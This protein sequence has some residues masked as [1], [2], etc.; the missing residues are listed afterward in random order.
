MSSSNFSDASQKPSWLTADPALY[1]EFEGIINSVHGLPWGGRFGVTAIDLRRYLEHADSGGGRTELRV[2]AAVL[3]RY[4]RPLLAIS[5]GAYAFEGARFWRR[6]L[7]IAN[8]DIRRAVSATAKIELSGAPGAGF[9]GT[10]FLIADRVLLTSRAAA[11]EVRHKHDTLTAAVRFEGGF[12]A[13]IAEVLFASADF[14]D[15]FAFLVVEGDAPFPQPVA[16]ARDAANTPYVAAVAYPVRDSRTGT[17]LLDLVYGDNFDRLCIAPGRA[18]SGDSERSLTH[19]CATL[20]DCAGAIL[21]NLADGSVAGMHVAGFLDRAGVAVGSATILKAMETLKLSPALPADAEDED[22]GFEARRRGPEDYAN[23]QALSYREDFL[24]VTVLMPSPTEAIKDDVVS[25]DGPDGKTHVLTYTHFAVVMSRS[26]KMC[27]YTACNLNG[28][29]LVP[30]VRGGD[31]W[32]I[33]PR[34]ERSLQAGHELYSG[35][36]LNRGHMV[37]RLDPVWGAEAELADEDTFHFTNA[38]PQ[39]KELNQKTWSDLE[40]YVL[41]NAGSHNLKV[42]V[43]TGPVFSD[44][45]P[46]YRGFRLPLQFWKV[47]VMVKDDGELLATAYILSQADLL[48]GL[49]FVFGEF[50]TYQLPLVELE[51]MTNLDFG[52]LRNY[53]PKSQDRDGFESVRE[54]YTV[55]RGPEDLVMG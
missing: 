24:G 4:A 30:L 54:Q 20:G 2:E 17:A 38:C 22:D 26:R 43:F 25:Y 41:D 11:L 28:G 46:D 19:D 50:R 3:A 6:R 31:S 42:T 53:D 39:H 51:E 9:V 33:D 27:L 1:K 37:R 13:R 49:E 21:L 35:S 18:V 12:S 10:A 44:D 29:E 23:R 45:D 40:D 36:D 5:D 32:R 14:S 7:A 8:A 47:V 15:D 16:L 55:I 34:I 48:T 52:E